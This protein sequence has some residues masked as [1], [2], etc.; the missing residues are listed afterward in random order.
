MKWSGR[1]L[2]CGA[3]GTLSSQTIA[4][5]AETGINAVAPVLELNAVQGQEVPRILTTISELDRVLGGGFVP[6][7]LIL[8]GGEP[9]IG[10]STLVLQIAAVLCQQKNKTPV[11][12]VS[13][14]ESAGQIKMRTDR[15]GLDSAGIFFINETDIDRVIGTMQTH[16]PMLTII[17]SIQTVSS[18]DLPSEAGGINQIRACTVKL[19]ESAKRNNLTTIIIGH[20]TK[21][22]VVAGPKTLEHL[23]DTVLYLEGDRFHQYRILRAVKNRFGNT[24]EIGVFEMQEKGM[25]PVANPSQIFL[26][27]RQHNSGSVITVTMEGS[28]P[29]AAEIQA[30]VAPT[31]FGYPQRKTAGFDYNRL[32]TLLAVLSRRLK[33]N[34]GNQDVYL[35]VV[36]GLTIEEPA[37]D[38]AASLAII[39]SLKNTPLPADLVAFGEVGLGG[40]VRPVNLIQRRLQEAEHLGFQK[41]C[42]PAG[43][44]LPSSSLQLIPLKNLYEIA[45]LK[46]I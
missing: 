14:E 35:N 17:D 40:E 6:G 1:C 15:L 10:K 23:V 4:P 45:D 9:G 13:G 29:F 16:K 19:M 22:G 18:S 26:Q 11:L 27:N 36:G 43:S 42:L 30:L 28:R 31:H 12:Y 5:K 8:I 38:L 41:I 25:I 46:I 21:E 24:A 7:S 20:I 32:Q 34:L 2:E 44:A 33:L 3:W 37:A 39:S